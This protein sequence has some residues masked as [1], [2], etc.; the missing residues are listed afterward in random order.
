MERKQGVQILSAFDELQAFATGDSKLL[1]RVY[2]AN[3]PGVEAYV[4]SNGGS[5]DEARDIFQEG[6]MTVWLNV[7][8]GRFSPESGSVGGYLFQICKFKWL[9]RL[10][11]A[12]VKNKAGLRVER[13]EQTEAEGEEKWREDEERLRY[14][15]SL[16]NKLGDSCKQLLGWFYFDK[17]SMDEIAANMGNTAS[18]VKTMKYRCMEKLRNFHQAK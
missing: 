14:L 11:S 4:C 18:T 7:R 6:M 9:D 16:F 3:Y 5:E 2:R 13:L 17:L 15:S 10:K 8:E 12:S 1:D